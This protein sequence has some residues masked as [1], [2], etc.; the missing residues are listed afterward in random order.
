MVGYWLLTFGS[1]IVAYIAGVAGERQMQEAE[2]I[3][4]QHELECL[5]LQNIG[6]RVMLSNRKCE[7]F[8]RQHT[9]N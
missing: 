4:L 5:R 1:V 2:R 3:K 7:S 9:L 6:Y 8:H